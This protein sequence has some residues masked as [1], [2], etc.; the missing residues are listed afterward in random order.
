VLG[1]IA[2]GHS[3]RHWRAGVQPKP[4]QSECGLEIAKVGDEGR[5]VLRSEQESSMDGPRREGSCVDGARWLACW[6]WRRPTCR[7]RARYVSAGRAE[8]ACWHCATAWK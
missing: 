1:L 2:H 6:E 8:R 3:W 5:E 4:K 7:L